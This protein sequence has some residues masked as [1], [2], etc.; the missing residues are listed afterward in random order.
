MQVWLEDSQATSQYYMRDETLETRLYCSFSDGFLRLLLNNFR[1]CGDIFFF[2]VTSVGLE[3]TC[4]IR[5]SA[6]V[7]FHS[8]LAKSL[9]IIFTMG[10][11][12]TSNLL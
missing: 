10:L 4:P 5:S 9:G 3:P 12:A 1:N 11:F 2:G 6:T 7:L 8:K